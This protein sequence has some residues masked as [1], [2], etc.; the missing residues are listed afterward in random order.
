VT[1]PET[2][3]R[4]RTHGFA[5]CKP[6]PTKKKPTY[7]G[8]SAKSLEPDDFATGDMLGIIAGPLSDGTRPGHALVVIDLDAPDAVRLADGYLPQTGMAEGRAGKP[9]SHRYYLV[10]VATIPEWA[11]SKAPQAAPAAQKATGHAGAFKKQLR[12]RQTKACVIDFLGTGGQCVCPPST[13]ASADG[14]RTEPREWE[15]GMPGQP[16]VVGFP[17]FWRAVCELASACGAAVPDVVPRPPRGRQRRPPKPVLDRARTYLSAMPPAVSGRGGHDATFA[18]A[19]AAVYGFDLGVDLGFE[20][21]VSEFNPRCQPPWSEKELRHKCQDAD[22]VPFDRP[23]GHLRDEPCPERNGKPANKPASDAPD[24]ETA[25]TP[26]KEKQ[27]SAA[28]VLAGIGLTFDLWHDPTLTGF[29]TTGRL[30]HPIRSK[31]F[32]HLLVSEYRKQT[33]KVPNSEAINNALATIEAAAVHDGPVHPVHVRVAESAGRIYLSLADVDSTVIEIDPAGWRACDEPPV[34]FRKAP[35]M[36]ALPMPEPGGKTD[37]LRAFLNVPD[38]PTFALVLAWLASAFRPGGPFPV[39]VLLGEQGSAKTT[40]A[41]ALRA[42]L[43]PSAAPVRCE[44][45]EARDLMIQARGNWVLALDNLSYLPPWLSDALCRLAT[46]GGFS[47]RELYT[48]DEEVIFDSKRPVVVNGIEDFVTRADL[49]ERSLLIR[50]PPIPEEK[51][52]PES[53]FWAAF[54][55]AHPRLLGAILDRVSAGLRERPGVKLDRLPRMADFALFA[56]A[57]ETGAGEKPTFLDAYAANQSG[58]HE[59]ALDASPVPAA[60]VALMDGR[61]SWEGAPAELFAELKRYTTDPPPQD[62]PKKPNVLTNRLRRLAPNLRRV[63]RLNVEDGRLPGGKR[64]RFVRVTRLPDA[65]RETPSPSSPPSRE[66]GNPVESPGG[67]GDDPGT[68]PGD[69]DGDRPDRPSRL[70]CRNPSAGDGRDGRDGGSR[71]LSGSPA[72]ESQPGCDETDFPFG[73]NNPGNPD[74]GRLFADSDG[75]PD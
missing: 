47:T 59:Q 32:K 33:A 45:K 62:W 35:G 10:P 28:E 61:E 72:A 64:S 36:L 74:G 52:R 18:A 23:R 56:V 20:L 51:R 30:S 4:L 12:H 65:A 42:L 66:A 17:E 27:P 50:L 54:D 55:A 69:R 73:C 22:R 57:C 43:D 46:G 60:L 40:T 38:D 75:L 1:T 19:R 21:L 37:D 14:A 24:E 39:V 41:R 26:K 16:A 70:Q 71:D 34:R 58:A 53:E 44:P 3:A 11:T 63:H 29:A 9:R 2:A 13:W 6:D 31:A 5:L 49:L 7:R 15:G 48:N 67:G 8:W 68:V 25:G